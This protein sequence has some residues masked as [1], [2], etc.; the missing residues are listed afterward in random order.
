MSKNSVP[1][2]GARTLAFV[3]IMTVT[4][5]L[6]R[7]FA[8]SI[9][10]IFPQCIES[11][12]LEKYT[13]K[14]IVSRLVFFFF[15]TNSFDDSTDCKNLWCYVSI[16]LETD[17]IFPKNF[18]NFRFY[19]IEKQSIISLN[20]CR[21]ESYAPVVLDDSEVPFLWEGEETAFCRSLSA[22][23]LYIRRCKIEEVGHQ[24]SW[25]FHT[26]KSISSR[27]AAFLLLIFVST[28]LSSSCPS[29]MSS[30]RFIILR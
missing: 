20:R 19:A 7:Q 23:F 11:N 18:L 5:S 1:S 21:G 26:S 6:G 25:F 16:S 17:L 28:T 29:L 15:C 24:I 9:C 2:S 8:R 30:W 27:L 4:V 12:A 13:N 3:F 22:V 10:S 14:I